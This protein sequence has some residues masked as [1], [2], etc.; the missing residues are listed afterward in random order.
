MDQSQI[1]VVIFCGGTGTRLKE[2]TEFKPKPMVEVGGRPILWHIMKGYAHH[3]YNNFV[4]ALG[5]KGHIIKQWFLDHRLFSTDFHLDTYGGEPQVTGFNNG[6]HFKI[7]FAETGLPTL[8]GE[9]LLMVAK[10][11]PGEQFMVT[12]GDGVTN[13]DINVLHEYHNRMERELGVVGTITGVHPTSKYGL[14][15][16]DDRNLLTSFQQKP[17]LNDYTNGGFMVFNKGFLKYL[18]PNQMIEDA[19]LDAVNDRKIALYN[20]DG[21]WHCM[22]TYKD[23]EDLNAMW[24]KGA[25]WKKWA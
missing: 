1:P 16:A 19:I 23:M 17:K 20:H 3:G 9:R 5:Y 25:P 15:T 14:V 21:F 12:Y 6:D 13:L 18:K 24:Q 10:Y 2:E 7:T 11:L 8:T 4:V 22:D